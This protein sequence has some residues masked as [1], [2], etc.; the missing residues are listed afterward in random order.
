MHEVSIRRCSLPRQVHMQVQLGSCRIDANLHRAM[1]QGPRSIARSDWPAFWTLLRRHVQS[2][3]ASPGIFNGTNPTLQT[4][5]A[6]KRQEALAA[7][8]MRLP[9]LFLGRRRLAVNKTSTVQH[10]S[11][12]LRCR[13]GLLQCRAARAKEPKTRHKLYCVH[14]SSICS[15]DPRRL[16][17][18]SV[19]NSSADPCPDETSRS[20]PAT[21]RSKRL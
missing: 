8:S 16:C 5:R 10:S 18:F 15:S 17:D 6:F 11:A 19:P 20:P 2:C 21:P 3:L 1:S 7:D 14:S 4:G 12:P 13:T 9:W